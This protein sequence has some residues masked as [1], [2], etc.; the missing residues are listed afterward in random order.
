M[1]IIEHALRGLPM[2]HVPVDDEYPGYSV[3]CMFGSYGHVVVV[4]IATQSVRHCVMARWSVIRSIIV[5]F[6]LIL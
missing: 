5:R 2:V 6:D 1:I 4:A 3:E